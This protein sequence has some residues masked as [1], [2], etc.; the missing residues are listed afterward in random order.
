M[1]DRLG[2]ERPAGGDLVGLAPGPQPLKHGTGG[3]HVGVGEAT[4]DHLHVD[5]QSV[6]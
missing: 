3:Q 6:N 5:G 1:R 2:L 4:T